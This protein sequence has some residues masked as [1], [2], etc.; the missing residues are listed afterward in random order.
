MSSEPIS[1]SIA[2]IVWDGNTYKLEADASR[3]RELLLEVVPTALTPWKSSSGMTIL[4]INIISSP[5]PPPSASSPRSP[6]GGKPT[7]GVRNPESFLLARAG[8]GK[9]K[10][11]KSFFVGP[12]DKN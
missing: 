10:G 3:R 12:E 4:I 9:K 8:E 6:S 2:V 11:G 5:P 1:R 7:S